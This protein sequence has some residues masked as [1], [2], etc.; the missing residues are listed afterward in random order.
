LLSSHQV[1]RAYEVKTLNAKD[2]PKLLTWKAF[3]TE[4]VD[5]SYVK[6]LNR[7]VAYTSGLPLALEVIGSN[8]FAKSV[9][10][11]K[12]AVN[13][14]KEFLIIKSLRYLK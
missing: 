1:K 14:Y 5:P 7:V 10:Q 2:A 13:K 12:S 8:L 11:L 9:E 4:Q 3:K 6:V